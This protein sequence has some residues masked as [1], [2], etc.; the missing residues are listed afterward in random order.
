MS[1]SRG[2]SMRP[3]LVFIGCCILSLVGFGLIVNTPGLYYPILTKELGIS[4]AE[5]ALTSSIM[6]LVGAVTMAFAGRFMKKIDSRVL[7]SACVLVC[8][9]VFLAGSFFTSL[10]QFYIGF[11]VLGIA[12]VIPLTLAPSVLLANWFEDKLGMVM[13]IAGG[14]SGVGGMI[15]NPLVS[16]WITGLGWRPSYRLTGLVLS[17][18]ILPFSIFVFKFR[19]DQAK[20]EQAYGHV[21]AAVD[22]KETGSDELPGIAAKKAY[23]TPTFILLVVVIVLLQ[24]VAG[25]VQ[26]VSGY[27]VS[28]GLSLSQG[29]L[30][31]S[32]IMLGAAVGKAT[33]GILLDRVRTEMVLAGY[34]LLGLC[35]W[36]LMIFAT[37][38]TPATLAGCL[39]GLGQG[40]LLVALPWLI[41]RSFGQRD[42]AEI[43]GVV[44][45]FGNLSAA[46]AVTMHGAVFDQAG[47]YLP[48]LVGNVILY[49]LATVAAIVAFRM[50]PF[51]DVTRQSKPQSGR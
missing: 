33:I 20:G 45:M 24:L 12:Y 23:R 30:V 40:V 16:S 39:A 44:S 14:L 4:R 48:S 10:W 34:A 31:V 35:G 25:L 50:R 17:I 21:A 49:V 43:L 32:G 15:F 9:L 47:T 5:I 7:I 22:K 37:S 8:A 42:Y 28:R 6:N 29:A 41:R 18:C 1:A 36:G 51:R 2:S 3:W 13:G 27:E 19:P 38:P 11:A 26:H 46:V